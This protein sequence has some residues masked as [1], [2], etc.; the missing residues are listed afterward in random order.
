MSLLG[1]AFVMCCASVAFPLILSCSSSGDAGGT[2]GGGGAG[3]GTGGTGA[4]G[5]GGSGGGTTLKCEEPAQLDMTGTWAIF[6]QYSIALQ[7]QEGGAITMCPEDQPAS[8]TMYLLLDI[9]Q[10]GTS[11]TAKPINCTLTLPAVTG[12]VGTCDPQADNLVTVAI[13][14]PQTLVDSMPDIAMAPA[15]GTLSA[16]ATGATLSMTDRLMFLTGA[17]K[18]GDDLPKWV[19]TNAGCGANDTSGRDGQCVSTCVTDCTALA[20]SDA[21]QKVGVTFNVCGTTKEDV[22]SKV[23]CNPDDPSSAGTTIQGKAYLDFQTDPKLTG[24]V[25]SSCEA[26]GTY[27]ATTIYH[28]VGANL[29]LANT[30]ISVAS[31]IKSLPTYLISPTKS[32]FHMIRVDGKYGAADWKTDL[33]D[34]RGA[35]KIAIQHQ[36]DV[37]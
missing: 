13:L 9:T 7:K 6:L 22:A 32:V 35:C 36:N 25:K 2:S 17:T 37:M 28:M 24:T 1:R 31:S 18:G 12:L 26:S 33:S 10:T 29:Y 21:D 5:Q 11:I 23:K 16:A 34:R 4:A 8:S 15:A 3:G 30:Q 14:A 20:D 19:D 27:D